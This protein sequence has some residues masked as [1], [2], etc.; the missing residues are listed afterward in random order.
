M[1][2]TYFC[3]NCTW[4]HLT[5]TD[6]L[7]FLLGL[8]KRNGYA[9]ELVEAKWQELPRLG[10]RLTAVFRQPGKTENSKVS[11]LHGSTYICWERLKAAVYKR[12]KACTDDEKS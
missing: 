1:A 11:Y 9:A 2:A 4:M 6:E 10:R 5:D 7:R 3:K 12:R 8:M